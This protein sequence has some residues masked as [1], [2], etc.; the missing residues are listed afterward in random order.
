MPFYDTVVLKIISVALLQ[1]VV[2][3][4][5]SKVRNAWIYA[6][7]GRLASLT[8]QGVWREIILSKDLF[9]AG[10]IS[11]LIIKKGSPCPANWPLVMTS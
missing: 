1:P 8:G 11:M 6:L 2:G 4:A 7:G 3:L 10:F 9:C 5:L